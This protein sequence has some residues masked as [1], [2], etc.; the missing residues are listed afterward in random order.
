[1][2]K[3]LRVHIYGQA[4]TLSGDLEPGYVE[5][6]AGTVDRKMRAL[7]AQTQTLDTRRLAILAALNLADALEQLQA[8][9]ESQPAALPREFASRLEECNRQLESV[10]SG[11]ARP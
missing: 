2:K 7:A 8:K 9:A 10:L 6:L 11:A 3:E 4:L 5:R 1:M